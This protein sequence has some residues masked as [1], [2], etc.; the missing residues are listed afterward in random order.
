[1]ADEVK[2]ECVGIETDGLA[3]PVGIEDEAARFEE[4]IDDGD[5]G[6]AEVLEDVD[7]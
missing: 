3:N 5:F 4:D 6:A 2:V 1:V 7:G